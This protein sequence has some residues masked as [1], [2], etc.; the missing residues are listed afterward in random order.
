MSVAHPG[1]FVVFLP[2]GADEELLMCVS[3]VI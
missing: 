2:A 3:G 1:A